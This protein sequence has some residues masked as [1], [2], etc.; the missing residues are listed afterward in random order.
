MTVAILFG[1]PDAKVIEDAYNIAWDYLL[2][3]GQIANESRSHLLLSE[4]IVHLLERG[5]RHPLRLA[6]KAIAAYERHLADLIL[7]L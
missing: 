3:S 6:N 2:R 1:I 5:E 7:D 4:A